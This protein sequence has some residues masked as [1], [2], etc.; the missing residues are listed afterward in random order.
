MAVAVVIELHNNFLGRGN[1]S[2]F[3]NGGLRAI[4]LVAFAAPRL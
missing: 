1:H 4:P 3:W 2:V